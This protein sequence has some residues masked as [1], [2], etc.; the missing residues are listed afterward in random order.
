MTG[1]LLIARMIRQRLRSPEDSNDARF[2]TFSA[3]THLLRRSDTE[4]SLIMKGKEQKIQ[5]RL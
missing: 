3:P 2:I 4:A 5:C 1:F